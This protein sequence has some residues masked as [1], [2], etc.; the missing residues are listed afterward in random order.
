[1]PAEITLKNAFLIARKYS[2]IN[3]RFVYVTIDFEFNKIFLKAECKQIITH[4][5]NNAHNKKI[6]IF[7]IHKKTV[8]KAV[9]ING[10]ANDESR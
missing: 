3:F 7:S 10:R 2:F 4:A 5:Y 8:A 1:M 9:M 6:F